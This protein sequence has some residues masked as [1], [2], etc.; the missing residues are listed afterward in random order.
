MT[1][2][3]RT[4]IKK[5]WDSVTFG[6]DVYFYPFSHMPGTL[7]YNAD[8]FKAAG[9][10]KY[11]GGKDEIKTWTLKD[12]E[13]IL[14][15]LKKDLPKDKYPMALYALNNQGDTWNLAYLR[16]FGNKFFDDKG[17][18]ILDDANGVKAAKWL[19]KIY[20]AGLTNPGA[21]S[22]SS[23]DA[24]AMFQ[25]QKLAISFTN[26]VLFNNAKQ[27]WLLVKRQSLISA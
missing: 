27:I 3:K 9:L 11:L 16:M 24:N 25:N 5:Y 26:S 6:K 1:L 22:V 20:D 13:T 7:A 2:R 8:M 4:L 15:A 21:E 17:N 18:I 14:N 10:E 23:N 12:Y 19:K